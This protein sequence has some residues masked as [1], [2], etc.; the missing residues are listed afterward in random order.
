MVNG[1]NNAIAIGEL[2][3]GKAPTATPTMTP[4]K[5]SAMVKGSASMPKPVSIASIQ[6]TSA[7]TSPGSK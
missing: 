5:I 2:R 3:P 7:S 6:F 4:M 1:N